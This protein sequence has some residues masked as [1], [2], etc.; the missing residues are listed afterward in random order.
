VPEP[1][2]YVLLL[3][4]AGLTLLKS[5]RPEQSAPWSLQL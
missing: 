4:G 1:D 3:L 5:R 2:T